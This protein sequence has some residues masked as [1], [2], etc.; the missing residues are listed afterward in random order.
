ML[1][2][3][4]KS[5]RFGK[6]EVTI[7]SAFVFLVLLG[8]G[9]STVPFVATW[10]GNLTADW[11]QIALRYGYW[12]AFLSAVVGSLTIVIVFPY[13]IV[14][15]FL[16]AQGLN[17]IYLGLL[18]GLGATIGQMSGYLIGMTGTG[19]V[20]RQKP[21][22]FDAIENIV[23][24]RPKMILWLLFVFAVTPLPDDVLFIPLGILRFP[25]WKIVMPTLLGKVITGMI[26]TTFGYFFKQA[27]D[28]TVAGPTTAVVSQLGTLAAIVLMVY[29]FLKLDWQKMMRRLIKTD[30][31]RSPIS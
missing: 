28:T 30:P 11:T 12:G 14:V 19:Y 31:D 22:T 23:A 10:Y 16:A 15:I 13:T 3:N 2:I 6:A 17:P 26:V 24:H 8:I 1:S 20:K 9:V 21:E 25:W 7:I 27:I 5:F 18:M 29:L 4:F